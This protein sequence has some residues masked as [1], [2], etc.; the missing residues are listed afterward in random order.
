MWCGSLQ[1]CQWDDLLN[2]VVQPDERSLALEER[3]SELEGELADASSAREVLAFA[4]AHLLRTTKHPFT[5]PAPSPLPTAERCSSPIGHLGRRDRDVGEPEP[6]LHIMEH[7]AF[8]RDSVAIAHSILSHEAA[9]T[10]SAT[11]TPQLRG[12]VTPGALDSTNLRFAEP[13]AQAPRARA[14]RLRDD[15]ARGSLHGLP[16]KVCRPPSVARAKGRLQW[17]YGSEVHENDIMQAA[18]PASGSHLPLPRQP[19]AVRPMRA[20]VSSVSND[21]GNPMLTPSIDGGAGTVT[22]HDETEASVAAAPQGAAARAPLAEQ[23][24]T[25]F[26]P[27]PAALSDDTPLAESLERWAAAQPSPS[28]EAPETTPAQL[29]RMAQHGDMTVSA[30]GQLTFDAQSAPAQEHSMGM[31]PLA[32]QYAAPEPAAPMLSTMH[33][34]PLAAMMDGGTAEPMA[35]NSASSRP[36]NPLA[37][38]VSEICRTLSMSQSLHDDGSTPMIN[39]LFIANRGDDMSSM[40]NSVSLDSPRAA[41]PVEDVRRAAVL[42]ATKL[43]KRR[44]SSQVEHVAGLPKEAPQGRDARDEW[45]PGHF[46]SRRDEAAWRLGLRNHD[47]P[48]LP[49]TR[50]NGQRVL[51]GAPPAAQQRAAREA[52]A[53]V[54]GVARKA[55]VRAMRDAPAPEPAAHSAVEAEP[56]GALAR[57]VAT[58][59]ELRRARQK[60]TTKAG[61]LPPNRR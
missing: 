34:A 39:P 22:A 40:F 36:V 45:A 41:P 2:L 1:C 24:A 6:G 29:R 4:L 55:A 26:Q 58:Y 16:G 46:S 31:Q 14:A 33:S 37:D 8:I 48:L 54:T 57:A 42:P 18:Q 5:A 11:A 52:A 20:P 60:G 17:G 30:S 38:D 15:T 7:D 28:L 50:P 35:G 23:L 3:V 53:A 51:N 59:G 12:A 19:A 25:M 10:A 56:K 44:P 21:S 9:G 49:T 61:W 13:F 47:A 27:S 32:E 43:P